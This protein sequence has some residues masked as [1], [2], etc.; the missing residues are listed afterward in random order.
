MSFDWTQFLDLAKALEGAPDTPGPREAALRSAIS[1]AYYAA[2]HHAL[3]RAAGEGYTATNTGEDHFRVREHFE[4]HRPSRRRARIAIEL[5]RL[6]DHRIKA[7]Y[8]ARM[9][10]RPQA[11]ATDAVLLADVVIDL[12]SHLPAP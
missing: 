6:Y 9:G 7:D 1:R 2:F 10:M 3:D 8:R 12:V 4:L 11:L 5:G